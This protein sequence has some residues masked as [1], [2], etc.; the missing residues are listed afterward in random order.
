M[1]P[2]SLTAVF[3][4]AIYQVAAAD[5]DPEGMDQAISLLTRAAEGEP[6]TF[7]R[8]AAELLVNDLPVPATAPGAEHL[9][10][11]M[12]D[13]GIA[14]LRLPGR[15]TRGQ[16][17]NVVDVLAAVA[18]LYPGPD[19]VRDALRPSIPAVIVSGTPSDPSVVDLREAMFEMP[20]LLTDAGA[21]AGAVGLLN[22]HA[23]RS[24]FSARLDPILRDG[25]AAAE[26]EDF[27]R[28]AR[29]VLELQGVAEN[30]DEAGRAI[31]A[32]ERRR[33][34]PPETVLTMAQLLP[35]AETS[36]VIGKALMALGTDGVEA[37]MEALAMASSSFERRVYVDAL[38]AAPD[39]NEAIIAALG[40]TRADL[41]RNAAEIAGRRRIEGAVG[42]LTLLLRDGDEGVRE[43]AWRALERIGT[44][45]A[46]DSLY[47][48]SVSAGRNPST[49]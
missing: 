18:A 38:T 46:L 10:K 20:G 13:H 49:G 8:R 26:T 28:L 32:R 25:E 37:L 30:Q 24:R 39:A 3:A 41:L 31:V 15:L 16:W 9:L 43:A 12:R 19:E 22:P 17:R 6:T 14:E 29:A 5:A 36:P 4:A 1:I 34:V 11:A 27:E 42:P 23:E 7:V 48:R 35:R 45:E 40:S 2:V 21:P 33:L 47:G 44:R